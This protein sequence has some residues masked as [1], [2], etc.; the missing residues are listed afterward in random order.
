MKPLQV[1]LYP[2][3]LLYGLGL[4]VRNGLYDLGWI[5]S[6]RAALP[7]VV[8]GNLSVGGSGKTPMVEWLC[9]RLSPP[10][11]PAVLSRG[12]GRKTKG[13]YWVRPGMQSTETGDEPLQMA[14]KCG[15]APVAV[16][17]DRLAGIAQIAA[18]RSGVDLVLLDDAYQHRRLRADVYVLLTEF[19]HTWA[20]DF[21][22]PAGRLRDLRSQRRRAAAVV[23]TKCPGPLSPEAQAAYRLRL[24]LSPGQALFFCS[25]AYERA[26]HVAGPAAALQ[27]G[28]AIT[29]FAGIARPDSFQAHLASAYVLKKFKTFADHRPFSPDQLQRLADD[30]VT[31]AGPAGKLVCTEKDAVR[32][33]Q[34]TATVEWKIPLF[35]IPVGTTFLHGQ[36]PVSLIT[37]RLG[38]RT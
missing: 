16:C 13:F 14:H 22:L 28:D 38:N 20:D 15:P 8:V 35:C 23:V 17:E 32:I 18:E 11:S 2:F 36:D 3:S 27:A 12:Y 34:L 9:A 21:L 33:G 26:Q 37:G 29:A 25:L 7:T 4:V 5:A 30:C 19:G 6:R 31:F 10:F 24:K 1:L